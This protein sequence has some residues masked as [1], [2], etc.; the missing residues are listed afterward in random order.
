M[1]EI[2]SVLTGETIPAYFIPIQFETTEPFVCFE[3][4]API[5]KV[6]NKNMRSDYEINA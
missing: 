3:E 5:N 1:L 6:N 4:V 2:H